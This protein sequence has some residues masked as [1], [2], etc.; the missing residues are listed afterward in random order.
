M[1]ILVSAGMLCIAGLSPFAVAGVDTTDNKILPYGVI[2]EPVTMADVKANK[3][4]YNPIAHPLAPSTPNHLPSVERVSAGFPEAMRGTRGI[5]ESTA[6]AEQDE[7]VEFF[8]QKGE[9][10][11]EAMERWTKTVGYELVWQPRPEDGDV[12]FAA[13]QSFTG[14]F[15]E[16]TEDF[17]SIVRQQTIFDAKF[18]GNGVLRV[19][20]ATAQR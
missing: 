13:N 15:A 14:T 19:F 12:R 7:V 18:H 1:K 10:L 17:F 16:A 5:M 2:D 6:A 8:I 11:R 9:K 3:L 20:V 4:P